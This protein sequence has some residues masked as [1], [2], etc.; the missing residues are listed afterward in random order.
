VAALLRGY[1]RRAPNAPTAAD[2]KRRLTVADLRASGGLPAPPP[3]PAEQHSDPFLDT[4]PD[5][6]VVSAD[7]WPGS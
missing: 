3:S 7:T 6:A 2:A 1:L 4:S 5:D